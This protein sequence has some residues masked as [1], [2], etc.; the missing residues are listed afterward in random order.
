M[1]ATVIASPA[2]DT[3]IAGCF[4]CGEAIVGRPGYF[5]AFEN[6]QHANCC[7]G[8]Q[9]VAQTILD[10][11]LGAYYRQRAVPAGRA[12]PMPAS[13]R[14]QLAL[15]DDAALQSH[16]VAQQGEVC[17]STLL[18]DGI[19]C[20]ACV[21]LAEQ[22]L[23]RQPGVRAVSVN[24]TSQR[25]RVVWQA[26]QTSLS[27][28]LAAVHQVGY[29]AQPFDPERQQ[30]QQRRER[31]L[32][33]VRLLVAGL[34][35]M[36]VM[37]YAWPAYFAS[38]VEL[39]LDEDTL[40][41]WA[42]LLLTL[43]AATFCA[44][45]FYRNA[46]RDVRGG[47]VG[48]DVPVA[49]GVLGAF[50]PSV[51]ATLSHHGAV[52]FDSV[53]M[54]VFLLL[55]G[56]FLEQAARR[57]SAEGIDRLS[58][59]LPRFAHLLPDW[60][61]AEARE[62]PV[63]KL[64]VGDHVLVKPGET[65]PADGVLVE[66]RSELSEAL[67]SGESRP[68]AKQAGDAVIGGSVN[69]EQALIMRVTGVGQAT[70][71]AG[72]VRLMD[73]ALA[74]KPRLVAI[75]ERYAQAFVFAV[76]LLAAIGGAYWL[77]AAPQRALAIVVAV[78]VI[79]CPC[80]LAL[81]TPV[82]LTAATGA[83]ARRGLL[84][85]SGHALPTLANI[86]HV[87]FDKTGT[88]TRGEP[89]VIA[90]QLLADSEQV[91]TLLRSLEA[92]SEH[93]LAR[94]LLQH[95]GPG[96][97]LTVTDSQQVRGR[98]VQ[99]CIDGLCYRI[100]KA[101]YV[102]E[103]AGSPCP[104]PERL[105]LGSSA[106][107]LAGFVLADRLRDDATT[108]LAR[109]AAAGVEVL[110]ASGDQQSTVQAL[111]TQLPVSA[112]RGDLNPAAKLNWLQNLQQRGAVVLMVGDGVNDGP[113]LAGAALSAAMGQGADVA[114]QAADMVL[115]SEQLNVLADAHSLAR[116][117]RNIIRQNLLWALL[118]NAIAIPLALGGW[119]TPLLAGAG[120]ACSSLLVVLNALRLTR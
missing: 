116:R 21:W 62:T 64:A 55:G 52:Y 25:A 4:H 75:T 58:T 77:H 46:W 71:V 26:G 20:A 78:L 98:G 89:Q 93:P 1:T 107:W 92:R 38:R 7:A 72:I 27:T 48:M 109:F 85:A 88:L 49:L 79:T 102:A 69:G 29:S 9:A 14:Q 114:R 3:A 11:G 22:T 40:L 112:A 113:V 44:W 115:L 5:V 8:C 2:G 70:A 39:P 95:A 31:T 56:R 84:I 51:W 17:E 47:R 24:Y 90:A 57:R 80:A 45:P 66:G 91:A 23:R 87:M 111:A 34:S 32:S 65:L 61:L 86:T 33:L 120:M 13:L 76:L 28:L 108:T 110:I 6:Q 36:Q 15:Y 50:L 60:P 101:D 119:V 103:L 82:A 30:L 83:L 67:L 117:T 43:P 37:M 10:Q 81:A 59:L 19:R 73:R 53:S 63:V 74:E 12:E 99:A 41:R 97:L 104:A 68:I 54:F 100:G 118:Y 42:S 105:W 16:Y 94:A 96:P 18:L 106:G 35:M